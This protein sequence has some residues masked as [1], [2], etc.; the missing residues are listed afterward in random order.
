[1]KV[2]CGEQSQ[3][4]R[5]QAEAQEMAMRQQLV[6]PKPSTPHL[7]HNP[8]PPHLEGGK[9]AGNERASEGE[10]SGRQKARRWIHLK[11][12]RIEERQGTADR[13]ELI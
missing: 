12:Q 11:G 5:R 1:M 9:E 4:R 7:D 2:V 8:N 13:R 10:A 3:E 6:H